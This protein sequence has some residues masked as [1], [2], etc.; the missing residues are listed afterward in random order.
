MHLL[1]QQG[2]PFRVI[3][4]ES[5]YFG[6]VAPY[7]MDLQE[8]DRIILSGQF[9]ALDA[10]VIGLEPEFCRADRRGRTIGARPGPASHAVNRGGDASKIGGRGVDAP[11]F[12]PETEAR[13]LP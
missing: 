2:L 7:Q 4:P 6:L 12:G 8:F 5:D 3:G 10:F 11:V 13:L 1:A 9:P